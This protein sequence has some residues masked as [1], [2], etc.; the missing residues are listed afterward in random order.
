MTPRNGK[1]TAQRREWDRGTEL[2]SLFA[3]TGFLKE[4]VRMARGKAEIRDVRPASLILVS[5]PGTGKTELLER[6]K[7][8]N[9][10]LTFHSD[11]TVRGFYPVLRDARRGRTTH[12]V[13]T[14]FQKLFQRKLSVAEN[15][16][17]KIVQAMEEGIGQENIGGQHED[18]GGAKCGL[19]GALTNGT[20]AKR[21]EALGE[22]GFLSRAM[23]FPWEP[24]D[25]EIK[26]ILD[27]INRGDRSDL[28]PVRLPQMDSPVVVDFSPTQGEKL[29]RF[30]WDRM[31]GKA[32]RFF[33]RLRILAMAS[34]V[35]DGRDIVRPDDIL[36][37]MSFED[38]W[39]KQVEG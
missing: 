2:I 34:A 1:R 20:L 16:V 5:D 17:G 22:M 38:Y 4:R 30:A 14:E 31:K 29:K 7:L 37:I 9:G 36:R 12:L 25:S 19:I 23:V 3:M 39:L 35:L 13:L 32:L 27:R 10:W 24:P 8:S 28:E 6:F 33:Q 11:L 18:F 21:R 26:A 15:C